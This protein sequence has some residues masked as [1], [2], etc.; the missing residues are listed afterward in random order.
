MWVRMSELKSLM[1]I[2]AHKVTHK[3][4]YLWAA[5]Q[6]RPL[7]GTQWSQSTTASRN[8]HCWKTL[9]QKKKKKTQNHFPGTSTVIISTSSP[10]WTAI[11]PGKDQAERME[12]QPSPTP[13]LR[14][15]LKGPTPVNHTTAEGTHPDTHTNRLPVDGF[16][17]ECS[18]AHSSS[19]ASYGKIL[20]NA[21]QREIICF[22]GFIAQMELTPFFSSNWDIADSLTLRQRHTVRLVD[23]K[24]SSLWTI[25][26]KTNYH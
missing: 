22:L 15:R 1:M 4:V 3:A 14:W 8:L 13:H 7:G 16:M 18:W 10:K 11:S 24:I 2:L 23:M 5:G 12:R 6:T 25:V 9:R 19:L 26:M 20:L 17:H 21:S